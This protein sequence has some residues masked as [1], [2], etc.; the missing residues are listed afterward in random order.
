[1]TVDAARRTRR[2]AP[3][4]K[5]APEPVLAPPTSIAIGEIGQTIFECP[6]C[7][8]P[9]ALASGR[10]P[11]CGT[12]LVRGVT[13][14]KAS[15][16]VAMGLAAGLLAGAGGGLA[17]GLSRAPAAAPPV[18]TTPGGPATGGHT[19][20]SVPT[21]SA[22]A[23]TAAAATAPTGIPPLTESAMTQV[24]ATNGRLAADRSALRAALA[25][26]GF[27]PSAVAQILRSISAET[28]VGQQVADHLT[29]WSGS[30]AVGAQVETFYGSVHDAAANGLVASVR[31]QA[32]YRSAASAMIRLLDGL[33]AINAAVRDVATSAGLD[34]PTASTAPAP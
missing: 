32:A 18:A 4:A 34:L 31:N 21:A 27:D 33:P 28:I 29:G 8:R 1:M 30:S 9:L 14:R 24:I 20:V 16:F 15:G 25:A 26:P 6:S 13:L 19:G 12:H 11:G 2:R 23:A 7:S 22:P 3:A 17:F 10:C 5:S